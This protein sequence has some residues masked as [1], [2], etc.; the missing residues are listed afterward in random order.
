MSSSSSSP[1]LMLPPFTV[2]GTIFNA[3]TMASMAGGQVSFEGSPSPT[4]FNQGLKDYVR[5][6]IV[7]SG[8]NNKCAT[9]FKQINYTI[10]KPMYNYLSLSN[11]ML[12]MSMTATPSGY[13]ASECISNTCPDGNIPINIGKLQGSMDTYICLSMPNIVKNEPVCNNGMFA[14][15]PGLCISTPNMYNPKFT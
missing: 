3:Q 6:T 14:Q 10:Q 11:P 9:G 1:Q 2:T 12:S 5:D 13:T 4:Y 7:S 15:G 8:S